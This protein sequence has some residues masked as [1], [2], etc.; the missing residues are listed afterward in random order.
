MKESG[1]IA[2]QDRRDAAQRRQIRR[3]QHQVAA[4]FED[5]VHLQHQMHWIVEQV[6][7]ELTA[8]HGREILIGIGKWIL[9]RVE[10]IDVTG[11]LFAVR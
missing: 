3:G 4:R 5:A 8:Q 10:E 9:F 2:L 6:L 7:D 1:M 11:E